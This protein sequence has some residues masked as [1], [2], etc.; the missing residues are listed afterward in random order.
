MGANV[1]PIKFCPF[2]LYF[3]FTEVYYIGTFYYLLK[4]C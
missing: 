4:K 1:P 3:K 2:L